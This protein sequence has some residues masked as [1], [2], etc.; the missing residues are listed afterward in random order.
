[1]LKIEA[2]VINAVQKFVAEEQSFLSLDIYCQL[3]VRIETSEYPIHQ[4]VRDLFVGGHM[5]NYLSEWIH[6]KLEGGGYANLWRYYLPKSQIPKFLIQKRADGRF[7]LTKDIMGHFPLFDSDFGVFIENKR[8]VIKPANG[9]ERILISD[10]DKR[11]RLNASWLIEADLA[12]ENVLSV[13]VY[14]TRIEISL[15]KK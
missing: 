14:P 7:E 6:L 10:L 1:M 15:D 12:S 2:D 4:Q 5:L 8:L 3:G 11:L 13:M 9:Q